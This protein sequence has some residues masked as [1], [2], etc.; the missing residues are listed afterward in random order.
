MGKEG[1]STNGERIEKKV[2][3]ERLMEACKGK[4]WITEK[5]KG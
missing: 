1:T 2:N 5:D 4:K 3:G